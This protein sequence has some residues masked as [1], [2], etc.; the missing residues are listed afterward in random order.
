M[1]AAER[2]ALVEARREELLRVADDLRRLAA[3]YGEHVSDDS[4]VLAQRAVW[5]IQY[6]GRAIGQALS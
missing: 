6:H 3:A 4:L 1:T 5:E 2:R